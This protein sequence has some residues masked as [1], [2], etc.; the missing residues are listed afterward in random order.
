MLEENRV[1]WTEGM[2]L[3]V[4]HFQQADRWTER[5]VRAATRELQP[6][7]W[8]FAECAV[9][10]EALGIGRFALSYARGLFADGT[11]FEAPG[12]ADLPP[13]LE[14][15]GGARDVLVHLALPSRQPGVA[16][17]GDG[18]P[19]D[20]GTRYRR[21]DYAAADANADSFLDSDIAVGRL[22]LS[23]APST[24][25]LAGLEKLPVARI[26]EV[27]SDLSVVLDDRFIAP[28][29]NCAAQAPLAALL[30][31]LQGLVSHRAEAI[32][33]RIADPTV[34]GTAEIADFLLLQTLNRYDPALRHLAAQAARVHPEEFYRFCLAAAGELSTFTAASK[35][36]SRYP[37]YRHDDLQASF[38]PVYADL[39]ASLSAVLEQTA[40]L[41]DLQERRHG[42]R[43]GTV[44]DRSLILQAGFVL[45][46][47]A[48]MPVEQLRRQLP[49][50]IKVGP[51]EQIAQLVN[52]ALPGVPVRALS[53]APRQLPYRNGTVYFELDTSAALWRE[54][55]ASGAL[56]IHVA[57]SFPEIE[58]E[59]WAIRG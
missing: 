28:A 31:E 22:R 57:G 20:T 47:R 34:R 40:V 29:L 5:V 11:S 17:M 49:N 4:H 38:A 27:R 10:R 30:G 16:E 2:F 50:Q 9:D 32:A 18:R 41:I 58:L 56:A 25:P 53:V 7:P 14:L 26:V 37:D 1:A 54:L 42:V 55:A 3:R 33:A 51:V 24:G 48:N 23:F 39:R 6:Y 19:A 52:V 15:V 12:D 44:E 43:V 36:A 45:A 8:G 35:R 13:P 46:V 59:L 21:S